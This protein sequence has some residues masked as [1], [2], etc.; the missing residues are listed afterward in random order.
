M[1]AIESKKRKF[2]RILESIKDHSPSHPPA[3]LA[4]RSTNISTVSLVSSDRLDDSAKKPRIDASPLV[5][6]SSPSASTGSQKTPNYLPTNREAFLDRLKTFGPIT[7]W[8]IASNEPINAAAWARRG[9]KCVDTDTVSCGACD[10]RL[11]V[12]ID[13]QGVVDEASPN[14][15]ADVGTSTTSNEDEDTYGL[16]LEIHRAIVARY[17]DLIVIAHREDCPWRR[18]GCIDSIQRIEGLLNERATLSVLQSRYESM[19]E[20]TSNNLIPTIH[21]DMEGPATFDSIN[22]SLLSRLERMDSELNRSA[23]QLAI[24]GWQRAS[25]GGSDVVECLHCFRRLGLWLYRGDEPAI[26]K[27]D[28]V[29]SHLE[30][31][32]WRSPESQSTEVNFQGH[33]TMVP[34]WVLVARTL[35]HQ[36]SASGRK[37]RRGQSDAPGHILGV[38]DDSKARERRM[39]D[40]LQKVKELK[41]PFNVKAL[42]K[43]K[44]P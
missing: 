31:C 12:V 24:C 17:Q 18:R 34:G 6:A 35:L 28:V 30:Y 21:I 39:K 26:E 16:S 38:S 37:D 14:E 13:A 44:K 20:N 15:D 32:P 4:P 43:K 40:L 23:Y 11:F 42:L 29:E 7:K 3:K 2:D 19:T 41:K 25:D 9:W 33:K 22:T 5:Q 10:E 1:Y 8:H 36:E 27:L